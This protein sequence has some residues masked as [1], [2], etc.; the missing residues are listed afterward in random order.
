[1]SYA[2]MALVYDNLMKDAPYD[3]WVEY[4]KQQALFFN[5]SNEQISLVD[6]GCGTG[7]LAVRLKKDGFHVSGTDLS[8]TMLTIARRKAENLSLTFPLFQQDMTELQVD[9]KVDMIT[10]FCDSINYLP[11]KEAVIQTFH[12]CY[13]ALK[14]GGL[15][16]LDAHSPYKID[17][18][19]ENEPFYEIDEE[20]TYIWSCSE[21]ENTLEVTHDLTFFLLNPDT[22]EYQRFDEW[23][24]QKTYQVNEWKGFLQSAG[25]KILSVTADFTDEPPHEASER[26]FFCVQK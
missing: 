10:I 2:N 18:F 4:V 20:V 3:K 9:E 11:T 6:V 21:G 13:A 14:N 16:L 12:S 25:F 24:R 8:E 26:I 7:E 1:M 15:L 22:N 5:K 17:L 19:L 23:H